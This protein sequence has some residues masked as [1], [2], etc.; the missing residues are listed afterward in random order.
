MVSHLSSLMVPQFWTLLLI[1]LTIPELFVLEMMALS[2]F[3]MAIKMETL[4]FSVLISFISCREIPSGGLL[5]P[6]NEPLAEFPA[7]P[8]KCQIVKFHPLAKDVLLT[9]GNDRLVR[10]WDL[11]DTSEAKIV[12]QV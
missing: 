5:T 2:G 8:D 7:H 9:A 11:N 6:I 4:L 1:L 12:L 3:G 10:I